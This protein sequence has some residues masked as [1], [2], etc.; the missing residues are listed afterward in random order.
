ML[1]VPWEEAHEANYPKWK[2]GKEEEKKKDDSNTTN[3]GEEDSDRSNGDMLFVSSRSDH[4]TDGWILDSSCSYH[5]SPHRDW[6][7]TYRTVNSRSILMGNHAS[8]KVVGI[9]TI[10]IKMFDGVVENV[11][12]CEDVPNLRKNLVSHSTLDSNGYSY[13]SEGGVLKLG[14]H[15]GDEGL[16]ACRKHLHVI[17]YYD[18]RWSN[19]KHFI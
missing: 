15:G 6:F 5:M 11:G 16:E 14:C 4:F 8:C 3:V 10:R 9:G 1:Q 12:W 7:D 18:C 17:G 13:N 2:K 19:C